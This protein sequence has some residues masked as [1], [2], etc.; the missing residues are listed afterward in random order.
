[1]SFDQQQFISEPKQVGIL[2]TAN[3]DGTPNCAVIG[4]ATMPA[5]DQLV[6]ALGDNR[7]LRNL[8]QNPQAVF[9]AYKEADFLPA[10]QGVRLYLKVEEIDYNGELKEQR[11][12][13]ITKNVGNQAAKMM[14]AAA[15][16][17]IHQTRPLLDFAN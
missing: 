14:V 16:F 7:T 3:S 6:L 4:S 12:A 5:E 10:W 13:E 8:Q 9:I 2:S 1:M 17:S 15:R 11:V